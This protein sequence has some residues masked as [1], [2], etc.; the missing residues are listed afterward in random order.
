MAGSTSPKPR[1]SPGSRPAVDSPLLRRTA[2]FGGIALLTLLVFVLIGQKQAFV[3][4]VIT[5]AAYGLVALGLVL[6]YKSSG[7][8]NFAQGEF[9]TVAVYVLYLLHSSGVPYVVALL[10]ALIV[11][12]A[13]RTA[14]R[15][16]RRATAVRRPAGD[17]P[18]G[19][20]RRGAARRSACRS[21]S[22]KP[23]CATSTRLC[24][25]RTA[26]RCS[27][28]GSPT[29]GCSSS[30][31][32]SCWPWCSACFFNRTTLGLAILGASQEPTATELVG[33]SVRRL[34]TLHVGARRAARRP[35][36]CHRRPGCR[37][38]LRTRASS[39]PGS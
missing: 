36:R 10:G 34:S 4:G 26:S 9:G 17:P 13:L 2:L 33:I 3:I 8:F 15:T 32:C 29:S 12:V 35:R 31:C 28:S 11:A 25:G 38:R 23:G 6:I 24:P 16:D 19:H 39:R 30:S 20:G 5:G 1:T 37:Q 14:R 18:G 22:A 27:G 21:G 7:V